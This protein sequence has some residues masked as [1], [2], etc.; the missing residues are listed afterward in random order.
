M[1]KRW[2]NKNQ[3]L[4]L[5]FAFIIYI[6]IIYLV[7]FN[8][9]LDNME[10][11]QYVHIIPLLLISLSYIIWYIILLVGINNMFVKFKWNQLI[12]FIVNLFVWVGVLI[13]FTYIMSLFFNTDISIIFQ[14]VLSHQYIE[15][16]MYVVN[17]CLFFSG[18]F[19]EAL[20]FAQ[21]L[22]SLKNLLTDLQNEIKG[23][24]VNIKKDRFKGSNVKEVIEL[25][26]S[27]LPNDMAEQ[28]IEDFINNHTL[29]TRD[30]SYEKE[31]HESLLKQFPNTSKIEIVIDNK[32]ISITPTY[33]TEL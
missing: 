10:D 26:A 24:V 18:K 13:L 1:I 7:L 16:R 14:K 21:V 27:E 32:H 6:G 22:N 12:C 5:F 17:L 33:T 3:K 4:I 29:T 19:I 31:L 20:L 28:N 11:F 9:K 15:G 25:I 30:L 2:I 23:D 8:E